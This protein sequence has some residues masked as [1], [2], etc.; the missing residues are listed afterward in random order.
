MEM[1]KEMIMN[2]LPKIWY[3]RYRAKQLYILIPN[4]VPNINDYNHK[5]EKQFRK[6]EDFIKFLEKND[7]EID[8]AKEKYFQI[9]RTYETIDGEMKLLE[10]RIKNIEKIKNDIGMKKD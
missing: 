10:K 8:E 7:L 4:Y 6:T 9:L 3:F 5:W 1:K 2:L